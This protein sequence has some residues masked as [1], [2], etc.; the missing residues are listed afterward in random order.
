MSDVL[1]LSPEGVGVHDLVGGVV[2]DS[3]TEVWHVVRIGCR[4]G[5]HEHL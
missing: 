3:D 1:Y 4:R 5:V 2:Q